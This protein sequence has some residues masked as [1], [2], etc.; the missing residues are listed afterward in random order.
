MHPREAPKRAHSSLQILAG[1]QPRLRFAPRLGRFWGLTRVHPIASQP[2]LF[3]LGR[4][5]GEY[6]FLSLFFVR[7]QPIWPSQYGWITP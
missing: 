7:S 6:C 2:Q 1:A 5:D 4:S 3:F